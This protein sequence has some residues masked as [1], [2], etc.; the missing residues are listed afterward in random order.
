MKTGR[1]IFVCECGHELT[2]YLEEK[3]DEKDKDYSYLSEIS[4]H[5][6]LGSIKPKPGGDV[7]NII[8][9]IIN[10]TLGG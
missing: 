2:I 9:K 3:K 5:V 8:D 7:E 4:K 6:L 1:A 10:K